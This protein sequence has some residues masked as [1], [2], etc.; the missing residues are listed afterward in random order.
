MH[1]GFQG[2]WRWQIVYRVPEQLRVV[3]RTSA[4]DQRLESDGEVVRTYVGSALVSQE[5]ARTSGV[6]ALARFVALTNLDVLADGSRVAWSELPDAERTAG[7]ARALRAGFRDAPERSLRLGFD[8]SLRLVSAE[9]VVTVP[10]LGEGL[11]EARY[12]DY[13]RTEGRWL[14][15]DIRYRF[16]GAPLLDERVVTWE[17]DAPL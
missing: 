7:V 13:R 8:A 12:S 11:L 14:P 6:A 15:F 2:A 16:R 5:P 9:G 10:G 4:D 3:L 17:P 1:E